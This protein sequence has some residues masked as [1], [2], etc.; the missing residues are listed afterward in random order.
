MTL[1][2]ALLAGMQADLPVGRKYEGNWYVSDTT[3]NNTGE[4]EVYAFQLF[5]ETGNPNYVTLTMR[6]EAGRP[7]VVLEWDKVTFPDQAVVTIGPAIDPDSEPDL[8]RY[9]FEKSSDRV[10]RGLLASPDTSAD[11]VA[12]IGEAP[13]A[14][15]TAHTTYGS[16]TVGMKVAGAQRAWA[17]VSRHCPAP[18]MPL[19]PL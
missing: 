3:D 9:V 18:I 13:Y 16:Q 10:R 14:T 4:R 12:A 5:L 11:I 7:I 17:R 19:P 1:L 8:K 6:C 2:L 15:V